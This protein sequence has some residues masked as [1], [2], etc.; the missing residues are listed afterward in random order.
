M[1]TH[2]TQDSYIND[3]NLSDFFLQI[4]IKIRLFCKHFYITKNIHS[5][6]LNTVKNVK[7]SL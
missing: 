4:I 7:L 3:L 5:G 1:M 2:R 6:S